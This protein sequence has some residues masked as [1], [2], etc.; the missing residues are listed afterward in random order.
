MA[1]TLNEHVLE[2]LKTFYPKS[3][4]ACSA[5]ANE[6]T[7]ALV[8]SFLGERE[9]DM[10]LSAYRRNKEWCP[11][12]VKDLFPY[13]PKRK[14]EWKPCNAYGVTIQNESDWREIV[15]LTG[16]GCQS[17]PIWEKYNLKRWG[18][19]Y[20]RVARFLAKCSKTIEE[21]EA[22]ECYCESVGRQVAEFRKTHPTYEQKRTE[23][24][25]RF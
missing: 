22:A 16:V 10:I 25:S 5:I 9:F 15:E 20:Y 21:Q 23:A 2:T 8:G 14:Y 12:G 1:A 11:K 18:D 17:P 13:W 3:E 24:V 6:I 19:N 7:N 4:H